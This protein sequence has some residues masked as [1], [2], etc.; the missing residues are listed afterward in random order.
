MGNKCRFVGKVVFVGKTETLG[1]DA[2]NPFYKR[3]IVVTDSDPSDKR[4]NTVPFEYHGDKCKYLD[5]YRQG[6][7]VTVDFYPQGRTWK[8]KEGKTMFFS[9]NNIAFIQRGALVDDP[10]AGGADAPE[11]AEELPDGDMP[12]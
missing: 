11:S 1:K 12:F 5:G 8:N 10:N 9:S 6:D 2:A 4:Q 7:T 3:V